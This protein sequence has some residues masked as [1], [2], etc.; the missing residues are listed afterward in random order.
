VV[1]RA[2]QRSEIGT[3]AYHGGMVYPR[4]ASVDPARYHQGLLER[5]QAAGATLVAA[6]CAAQG[7]EA[8]WQVFSAATARGVVKAREV[9][10]ATN[11]YHR[12]GADALAAAPRHPDR[13]LHHRHRSRCP[14][15]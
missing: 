12:Q 9:V 3:D 10:V 8:G 4:H 15:I 13:Q 2:E 11:G 5:V 6:H 7:I 1:P 14:P